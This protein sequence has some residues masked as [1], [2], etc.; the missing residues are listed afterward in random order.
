MPR[1][2]QLRCF[3]ARRPLLA[4]YG[5]D[6]RGQ[7]YVHVKVYKGD[8]IFGEVVATG[9]VKIRCRECYRWYEVVIHQSNRA[10]LEET[11]DLPQEA[12][13]DNPGRHPLPS[14][15]ASA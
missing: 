8:R 7:L 3:C 13:A 2:Y 10:V 6:K 15:P 1:R 14:D 4:L 11:S 5:T 9:N 12:T